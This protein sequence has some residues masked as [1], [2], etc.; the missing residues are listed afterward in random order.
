MG[1]TRA[2]KLR[3]DWESIKDNIM[4]EAVLAKFRS[5]DD[6][7]QLLLDTGKEKL[8]ENAPSDYY[9]GCGKDGSGKIC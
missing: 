7:K 9:W 2:V 5:H 8:V 1:S 6:I 4:R 3:K